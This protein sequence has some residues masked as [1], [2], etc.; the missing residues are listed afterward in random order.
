MSGVGEWNQRDYV[1]ERDSEWG[2]EKGHKL[3]STT[4]GAVITSYRVHSK[5]ERESWLDT[6]RVQN[7]TL[8]FRR[9][10]KIAK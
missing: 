9:F 10:R 4:E 2:P 6:F 5:R 8:I 3:V 7:L 1:G